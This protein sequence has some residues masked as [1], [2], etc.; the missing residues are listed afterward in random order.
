MPPASRRTAAKPST[1]DMMRAGMAEI[2]MEAMP[3]R[4]TRRAKP[5]AKATKTVVAGTEPYIC[6]LAAR[7]ESA[8]TMMAQRS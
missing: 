4:L 3:T 8:R 5:P 7:M 1:M 6:H 2:Q